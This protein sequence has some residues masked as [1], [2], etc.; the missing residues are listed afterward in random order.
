MKPTSIDF[1]IELVVRNN[2]VLKVVVSGRNPDLNGKFVCIKG[3]TVPDILNHSERLKNPI[4]NSK[5]I[6]KDISWSETIDT[7]A[8]HLDGIIENS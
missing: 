3:L 1:Y 8:E 5:G 7:A 6:L 4:D 2:K